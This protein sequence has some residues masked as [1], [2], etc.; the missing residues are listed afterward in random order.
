VLA[1]EF[2]LT[3][4]AELWRVLP[5]PPTASAP[6]GQALGVFSDGAGRRIEL[7]SMA[8]DPA[9]IRA[10]DFVLV[11]LFWRAPQSLSARFTISTRIIDSQNRLVVQ[12]DSEPASGKRAT[13]G[14]APAEIVQ[15]D[16]G[17]LIQPDASPG[18]YRIGVI[19]YNGATGENIQPDK[20][21]PT[22]GELF[23]AAEI[24][25]LR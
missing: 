20:G 23:T 24:T 15:D 12:R 7:V 2:R 21:D 18:T 19:V 6:Q 8:I 3:R 1:D 10:G 22:Q 4:I 16:V 17:L 14:W 5:L 13:I 11:T 25:V 9:R